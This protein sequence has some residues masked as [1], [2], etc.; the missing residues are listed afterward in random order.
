LLP[1]RS[2]QGAWRALRLRHALQ[3]AHERSLLAFSSVAF[4]RVIRC[5]GQGQRRIEIPAAI[6][7]L[8]IET[9][10]C[11]LKHML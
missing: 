6:G 1:V 7:H 10:S 8:K 5:R 11:P 9:F 4:L 2:I 3:Q